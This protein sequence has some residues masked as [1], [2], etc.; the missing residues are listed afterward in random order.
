M[1]SYTFDQLDE[2][3]QENALSKYGRDFSTMTSLSNSLD[4]LALIKRIQS[5][6]WRFTIHGE[7]VA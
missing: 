3:G 5:E 1:Q 2:R 4:T 6:S 7:R